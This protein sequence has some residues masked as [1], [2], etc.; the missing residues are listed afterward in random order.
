MKKLSLLLISAACVAGLSASAQKTVPYS[1]TIGDQSRQSV[2]KEWT[3]INANE[4]GKKWAYSEYEYIEKWTGNPCG[5]IYERSLESPKDADDWV[6]SPSI[7]I[8]KDK[9]YKL[10]W[11]T[12]THGFKESYEVVLA[13]SAELEDLTGANAVTLK[14]VKGYMNYTSADHNIMVFTPTESGDFNIGFHVSSTKDAYRLYLTGFSIEDFVLVPAAVTELTAENEG[15]EMSVKLNWVLPTLDDTGADLQNGDI[16]A[17]K[18][19]RNGELIATLAG[20]ATSYTDTSMPESGFYTY[21]V[22]AVAE[23][24]SVA[25]SVQTKYVGPMAP[26]P[27]PYEADLSSADIVNTYWTFVDANNDGITWYY[28][29]SHST[30]YI[31]YGNNRTDTVEDDWAITPAL[32]FP[33]AGEYNVVWNGY[34]YKGNMEFWLGGSNSV[35]QMIMKFGELDADDLASFSRGDKIIPVNIPDPG[36]YYIG[37]HNNQSPSKGIDYYM[38]GFKVTYG[39]GVQGV[40]NDEQEQDNTMYDLFG[41]RIVNPEKGTI[42]IMNGKKY[43]QK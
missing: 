35:D 41:R 19:Y 42:Y 15:T 2:S 13:K 1:S 26:L 10:S 38:Y 31:V 5:V 14:A 9:K 33:E 12:F 27:V 28:Y 32:Y 7:T 17:V 40:V 22:T 8:E 36:V 24:E 29:N 16:K 25:T 11:W 23:G 34:A 6:V 18:V 3:V 4:D 43:I 39:T 21:S 37:V 30:I 20:D